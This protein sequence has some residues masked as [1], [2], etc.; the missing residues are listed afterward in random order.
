MSVDEPVLSIDKTEALKDHW[1]ASGMVT[2]RVRRGTSELCTIALGFKDASNRQ[3]ALD[4]SLL[5]LDAIGRE[6]CS[7][8]ARRREP[9]GG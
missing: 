8:A 3:E 9:Q 2:Y 4:Q 1:V 5:Q 6:L 7:Y